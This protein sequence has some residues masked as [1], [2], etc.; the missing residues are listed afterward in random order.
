MVAT[1][2]SRI[3]V[4]EDDELVQNLYRAFFDSVHPKE[5]FWVLAYTG[6]RALRVLER[7][8]SPPVDA[9]LLDWTLPEM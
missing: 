3:L 9:V 5:F 4:I 7:H 6:E 2:R 1:L 8:P